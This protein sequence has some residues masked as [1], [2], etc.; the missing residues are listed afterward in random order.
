[1][2]GLTE[3]DVGTCSECVRRI[4]KSWL[5]G[6]GICDICKQKLLWTCSKCKLDVRTMKVSVVQ[7]REPTFLEIKD[8]ICWECRSDNVQDATLYS[9]M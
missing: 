5:L 9:T 1:M 7:A 8:Q 3:N 4:P 2:Q 6:S